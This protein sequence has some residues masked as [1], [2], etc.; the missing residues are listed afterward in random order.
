MTAPMF[1]DPVL[2]AKLDAIWR[3]LCEVEKEHPDMFYMLLVGA[4]KES[5]IVTLSNLSCDTQRDVAGV[6]SGTE[7]E[8]SFEPEEQE[9][10]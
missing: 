4:K 8:S 1:N 5:R 10:N 6:L 7:F 3:Q 2:N 9:S